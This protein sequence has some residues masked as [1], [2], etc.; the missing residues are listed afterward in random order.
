MQAVKKLDLEVVGQTFGDRG[1][2]DVA[3]RQ[4]ETAVRLLHLKAHL[5]KVSLEEAAA[6]DWPAGL[7]VEPLTLDAP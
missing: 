5:W 2:L 1:R 4:S 7:L 6:L 3:I